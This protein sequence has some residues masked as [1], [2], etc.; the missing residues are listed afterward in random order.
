[1]YVSNFQLIGH[2]KNFNLEKEHCMVHADR[3]VSTIY[4]SIYKQ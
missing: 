3:A 2:T 1:M 4:P